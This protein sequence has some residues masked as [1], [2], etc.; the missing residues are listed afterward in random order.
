MKYEQNELERTKA[1][2]R[3][4]SSLLNNLRS[5]R[6]RHRNALQKAVISLNQPYMFG[7]EADV[8]REEKAAREALIDALDKRIAIIEKELNTTDLKYQ[9]LRRYDNG[10]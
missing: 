10:N 6:T 4:L 5:E 7:E 9:H 3:A 1:R 2:G 8:V